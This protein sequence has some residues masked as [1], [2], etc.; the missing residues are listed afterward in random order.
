LLVARKEEKVKFRMKFKEKKQV[1]NYGF[2]PV[3]LSFR[4]YEQRATS[5]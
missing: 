4:L 3:V 2:S 5:N 1:L